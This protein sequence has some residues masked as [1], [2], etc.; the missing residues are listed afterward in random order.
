VRNYRCGIFL[1]LSGG[2]QL[3]SVPTKASKKRQV[4]RAT[5]R[6]NRV[7]SIPRSVRPNFRPLLTQ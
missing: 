3:S 5:S 6:A 4:R 1:K 7:S 2:S